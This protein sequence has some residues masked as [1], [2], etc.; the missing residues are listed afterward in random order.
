MSHP[1]DEKIW[2]AIDDGKHLTIA[3]TSK[4]SAIGKILTLKDGT[5]ISSD[6]LVLVTGWKSPWTSLFPPELAED[7]EMRVPLA[8]ESASHKEHWAPV[9]KAAK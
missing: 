6:A 5:T 4:V 9:E 1:H 8:F 2:E 7:L 3:R